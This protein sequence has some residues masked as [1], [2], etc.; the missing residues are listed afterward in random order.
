MSN[1]R[2]C[3]WREVFGLLRYQSDILD[4]ARRLVSIAYKLPGSTIN[5]MTFLSNRFPRRSSAS[6]AENGGTAASRKKSCMHL[7]MS[8]L[9]TFNIEEDAEERGSCNSSLPKRF[10]RRSSASE[11]ESRGRTSRMMTKSCM[12]P[13]MSDLTVETLSKSEDDLDDSYVLNVPAPERCEKSVRFRTDEDTGEIDRETFTYDAKLQRKLKSELYYSG[14]EFKRKLAEVDELVKRVHRECPDIP[15]VFNHLRENSHFMAQGFQDGDREMLLAWTNSEGRG[16]E[17][18]MSEKANERRKIANRRILK[19]QSRR[20]ST[21]GT[22]DERWRALAERAAM[23]SQQATCLAAVI[24]MGDAMV[25]KEPR[26]RRRSSV[27]K[28]TSTR[29]LPRRRSSV[30]VAV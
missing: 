1:G 26:S 16:L 12:L 8:D 9:A 21:G 6:E 15:L 25:V 22:T 29:R 5:R 2:Q 10:P 19:F 11:A 23:E 24:G 3:D 4:P 20:H 17:S 18:Y 14:V 30:E 28:Q 27:K 7:S 13:S